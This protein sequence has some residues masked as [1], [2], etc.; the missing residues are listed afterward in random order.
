MEQVNE[1][2][3]KKVEPQNA[4]EFPLTDEERERLIREAEERKGNA[5]KEPKK[6]EFYS[7]GVMT[8]VNGKINLRVFYD[9]SKAQKFYK[10]ALMIGVMNQVMFTKD[11][12]EE[13]DMVQT[14]RDLEKYNPKKAGSILIDTNPADA[15]DT[16]TPAA[17]FGPTP[18][19][20][21]AVTPEAERAIKE[22]IGGSGAGND[23]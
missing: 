10:Q 5:P 11:A 18:T 23:L 16:P 21:V 19:D 14:F 12:E 1:V 13:K 22:S 17:G 3:V 6:K 15:I 2:E 4:P 9:E 7:I 8:R 20:T